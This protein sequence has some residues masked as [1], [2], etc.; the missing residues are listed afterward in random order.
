MTRPPGYD[1]NALRARIPALKAGSAHF[2]GPGGTQVPQPVIDA[3]AQALA[4]PLC[5]RG[6]STA[7]ERN[8][9][10]IVL[11]ARRAMGDFLGADPGGVVFGRSSTQLVYDFSRALAKTWRPGDEV[12]VTR[13]D[14]E[15]NVRPWVQAA[16]EAGAVVR[17]A[18]F[19]PATGELL[20]E[21][22]REVLSE[23]TRLVAVTAASNLIGTRP[24]TLEISR[25]AHRVGAVVHVDAAQLSAHASVD[26]D[27]LGADSV[28][29]SAYKFLGPHLGVLAARPELL[30]DLSP[31]KL[32]AS[33]DSV[34][35][36]F[37]L[38]ILPYAVLA[39]VTATVEFLAGLAEPT[40]SAV[41]AT[42]RRSRLVS[43]MRLVE[44]HE[45]ALRSRIEVELRGLSDVTLH[46]RARR[47]TPTMLMTV[48]GREPLDLFQ[49][50]AERGVDTGA[51]TF[52]SVA[53][54]HR[55]GLGDHGGVRV[56]L[57]PYTS[58]EDADRLLE[59]VSDYLRLR[60]RPARRLAA[61]TGTSRPGN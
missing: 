20:P 53:A 56:G 16:A 12:V 54:S 61:A 30:Y 48:E 26:L 52:Y 49:Y 13:L 23:R 21:H 3:I 36:R 35:E 28:S 10:A 51:G 22:I 39:G 27:R 38:G 43:S 37:E 34:P 41:A 2:D 40:G 25:A 42:D 4:G 45:D 46:A 8:A 55:L 15:C 60:V 19:D 1:I 6:G 31:D 58:D 50:L 11:E 7:G 9:E 18:D 44:A 5:N 33:T 14:H 17:W 59:G 47:R 24:D 57:A 29:C 32:Q